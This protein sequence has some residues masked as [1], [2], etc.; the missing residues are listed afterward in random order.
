MSSKAR[1]LA[2]PRRLILIQS[3][4]Y[5]YAE[6]DLTESFQL[7]GVNGLGKTALISTLQ[8]LYL[9]NQRDMRFG[10]HTTD[11]SRRFYFRGE[12]SFILYECETSIGTVTLGARSLGA[13]AGYE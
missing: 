4:K 7:V 8:Y 10:Q 5:D 9:D 13:T 2:G 1:P 3:G 11:E 6:L 12:A